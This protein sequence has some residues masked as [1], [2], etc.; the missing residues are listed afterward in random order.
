MSKDSF[1]LI[2]RPVNIILI[3]KILIL[4]LFASSNFIFIPKTS[5]LTLVVACAEYANKKTSWFSWNYD[6]EW[7]KNNDYCRKNL[8]VL[9]KRDICRI[10]RKYGW[11][12]SAGNEANLFSRKLNNEDKRLINFLMD[13]NC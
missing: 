4:T 10:E 9:K 8:R 1:T 6:E 3:K 5:A 13:G 7:E 2:F 12:G 11:K